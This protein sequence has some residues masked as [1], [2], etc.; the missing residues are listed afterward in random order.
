MSIVTEPPP[1]PGSVTPNP[2]YADVPDVPV[3]GHPRRDVRD[4]PLPLLVFFALLVYLGLSVGWWVVAAVVGIVLM[5]FLHELGHYTTAKRG[6]MKV[7][8]FFLGFG[9]RLW[10]FTR[11]E[12]TYGVKAIPLGAYVRIIGMSNLE[13]VEPEDEARTYRQASYPRRMLVA[14][15]GSTMHF[16]QAFILLMVV[17]VGIGI[18]TDSWTIREVSADSAAAA[19]GLQKGDALVQIADQPVGKFKDLSAILALASGTDTTIVY[20]RNGQQISSN[21]V[22]AERFDADVE[23][24]ITGLVSGDRLVS[25][26]GAAVSN[27]AQFSSIVTIGNSYRVEVLR[28]D[29]LCGVQATVNELPP[30]GTITRGFLGVSPRFAKARQNPAVGATRSI[31]DFGRVASGAVSGI[32][33]FVRPN[34]VGSFVSD[35]VKAGTGGTDDAECRSLSADENRVMSIYGFG[36][37]ASDAGKD[38][39]GNFLE[40]FALFNI[41]IGIFN[42]LPTLPFDGGHVV[43]ATYERIRSRRGKRYFA[44]M[45]KALPIVYAVAGIMVFLGVLALFRDIIDPLSLGG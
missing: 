1:P 17:Y 7:T 36:K 45:A 42:L 14:V 39:V 19:A 38:G 25:V 11:G 12:T 13:E 8:E 31:G 43:V 27:Y 2:V 3:G 6:G 18:P 24:A 35:T 10:S 37:V 40:L 32:A 26:D 44:D 22:I 9:P 23:P 34:N 29:K 21:A 30:A 5:I 20:S 41:F 4:G 28:A 33:R 16:I 15:A